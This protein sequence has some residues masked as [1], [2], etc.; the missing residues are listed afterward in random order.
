MSVSIF[1]FQ[2]ADQVRSRIHAGNCDKIRA[3]PSPKKAAL[4]A[5]VD[6]KKGGTKRKAD[7]EPEGAPEPASKKK[8]AAPKTTTTKGRFKGMLRTADRAAQS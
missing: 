4:K 8:K 7:D 2:V 6:S 1:Q 3:T 5:P